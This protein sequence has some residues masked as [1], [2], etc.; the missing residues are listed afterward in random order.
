MI[1][2]GNKKNL[3]TFEFAYNKNSN[4]KRDY[5]ILID[6]SFTFGV[7]NFEIKERQT[8]R[9]T[10]RNNENEFVDVKE[11]TRLE[12]SDSKSAL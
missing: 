5:K 4:S 3:E 10:S 7:L 11:W 8:L 1:E 12:Q 9:Q 6:S 2:L